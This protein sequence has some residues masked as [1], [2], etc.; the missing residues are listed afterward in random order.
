VPDDPIF[1]SPAGP[2]H[3]TGATAIAARDGHLVVLGYTSLADES[4]AAI[5]WWSA[6][7]SSWS[8]ADADGAADVAVGAT[9]TPDGFLALWAGDCLG[10]V[11]ASTDGHAWH[12]D[13]TE[14]GFVGFS[15]AAVTASDAVEVVVG[16]TAPAEGESQVP[17]S[18][19]IWTRALR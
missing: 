7:G 9:G 4:S 13:A 3:G 5:A 18:S 19:S 14:P 12:C 15:P 16:S 11:W 10:G 8:K 2:D 1:A 17:P 6:S